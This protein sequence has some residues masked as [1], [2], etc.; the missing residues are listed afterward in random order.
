[1]GQQLQKWRST[2]GEKLWL[3]ML[4]DTM[5]QVSRSELRSQPCDRSVVAAVFAQLSRPAAPYV[6]QVSGFSLRH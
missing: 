5:E 6:H 4:I 3:S 1:M 2:G